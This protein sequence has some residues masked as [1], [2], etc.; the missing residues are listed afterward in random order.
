[1]GGLD[2]SHA[3]FDNVHN[4]SISECTDTIDNGYVELKTDPQLIEI[5]TD[6]LIPT[7]DTPVTSDN[8]ISPDLIGLFDNTTPKVLDIETNPD[9][10][11]QDWY[12]EIVHLG[13]KD[14]CSIMIKIGERNYKTLWDSGA[15]KCV[16]SYDKFLTISEKLKSPLVPSNILI[17]AANGSLIQNKGECDITFKIGP[18]RFTFTF[19][20]SNELTQDIILGYN[21]SK[22][23]HIGTDWNKNDEMC[24]TRNG[25]HLTTTI[26]TK[27]INALVQCA[28][29]I[30]IPPRSN[31]MVKCKAP[32]VACQQHFEKICL[33]EP[34]SKHTSDNAACHTYNG[35]IVMDNHV[36]SSGIFEI[37]FT[38]TSYKTVILAN[39]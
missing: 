2:N 3:L 9:I 39:G 24:L 34:S 33:F 35:T 19:L 26:S 29:V 18:Q 7:I 37:A 1:M 38:N 4:D 22:A 28:E 15:G 27:A 5:D 31:A 14:D 17:K 11:T 8:T 30:V 23:Y 36:A 10:T 12:T 32:K 25:K 20:V 6:P 21:F 16:I 13:T